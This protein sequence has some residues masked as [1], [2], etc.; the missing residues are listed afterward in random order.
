MNLET[1]KNLAPD[2]VVIIAGNQIIKKQALELPKYGFINAH[3]SFLPN[4]KGLMPSFWVLRNKELETGV[5]VFFLRE[6]IDDGPIIIQEKI[7]IDEKMTQS[8]LIIHSKMLANKL[9]VK[10]LD[11]IEDGEVTPLENMHGSY[12]K[13]PTREDVKEFHKAKK[14]FF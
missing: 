10:A 9:I 6:G 11:L 12:F 4:Y 5:S 13:F 7:L 1:L 2:I 8:N 14:K 3:S